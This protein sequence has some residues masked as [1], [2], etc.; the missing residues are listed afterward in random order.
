MIAALAA[1]ATFGLG[2]SAIAYGLRP[3]RPPLAR[4]LDGL[5]RP[6]P[7]RPAGRARA[8]EAVAVPARWLG[9]PRPRVALDL[10]T[11]QKDPTQH[12]AEQTLAVLVGALI[13][14]L[15][16]AAAGL[17][18]QVPL[19]LAL[20]GG[21]VG[22]RW[23]D[24]QLR[25][26]AQ[27]RRDQLRHTLAM[28]LT[29][30]TISLARGAGVEQA[31]GESSSVCTGPAADR[32]RQVL[33]AARIMRRPP[34]QDLGELGEATGVVELAELAAAMG[35]AGTEGARIRASLAARAAAMRQ[36]AT[37]RAETE[38]DKAS[39]RMSVPLLLLGL[40]YLIFLLYPPIASIGSSL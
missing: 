30:L 23:A 36:A 18:G 4:V 25:Q 13:I 8:Y 31:L 20:F 5:R 6:T 38:A 11:M 33:S 37:A 35:L 21:A 32:L 16:A 40:A 22:F 17:S 3:P 19:W 14:P 27:R 1:G 26:Q 24:T 34:W 12:L 9:L 39:S 10:A 28:L 29:L 15:A 7:A 2:V